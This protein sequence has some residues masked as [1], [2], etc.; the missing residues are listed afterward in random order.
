[1][2]HAPRRFRSLL[3]LGFALP[4]L[5]TFLASPCAARQ[6]HVYPDGSGD[7]PTIAAAIDSSAAGDEILLHPG[8][9][10]EHDLP[11]RGDTALRGVGGAR[12]EIVVDGHVGGDPGASVFRLPEPHY[13]IESWSLEGV[14]LTGANVAVVAGARAELLVTNCV[15]DTCDTGIY[16]GRAD[17]DDCEF[18]DIAHTGS[19]V[20]AN[21]ARGSI[22][23]A[24]FEGI[25]APGSPASAVATGF[26][27]VLENCDFLGNQARTGGAVFTGGET[28]IT[29]CRFVG[30]SA[31]ESGGAL[32]VIGGVTTVTGCTFTG[33][34]ADSGS[35]AFVRAG[36]VLNLDRCLV[37]YEQGDYEI[38]GSPG[39][40]VNTT[41]TD[42]YANGPGIPGPFVRER[43]TGGTTFAADPL[44]CSPG[45]WTIADLS[46]CA[47][48]NSPCGALIGLE[49][50]A[51]ATSG[52]WIETDPPGLRVVGDGVERSAAAF[53]EWGAG[54]THQ[55]AA[56]DS[57]LTSYGIG[58]VFR[59]WDDGGAATHDITVTGSG[60]VATAF[61]DERWELSMEWEGGGAVF[62]GST[63]RVPEEVVTITAV[64][65]SAWVFSHWWGVGDGSYSGSDPVAQVTMNEPILQHAVFAE[66][67]PVTIYSEPPGRTV[68]V[69]GEPVI[70]PAT[71]FWQKHL[72]M[73]VDADAPQEVAPGQRYR[74]VSWSDGGAEEHYVPVSTSPVELTVTY[75]FEYQLSFEQ[76]PHATFLPGDSWHAPGTVLTIEA[77]PDWE[78]AFAGWT[79]TGAASYTGPDNPTVITLDSPVHEDALITEAFAGHGYDFSI[80][81]SSTDPHANVA[82]PTNTSR[83]LYLWGTCLQ[84]GLAAFEAA[85]TG[86][87]PLAGFFPEPGI[88]NAGSSDHLFLAV[89]GCPTGDET[90]TLLG[91]WVITSD[92]GGTL[93]LSSPDGGEIAVA[94][95][96][97]L[98]PVVWPDPGVTGFSSDGSPPCEVG[99]NGCL[100]DPVLVELSGLTAQATDGV[101]TVSWETGLELYHDGFHVY[102]ASLGEADAVRRT[103]TMVRGRSPYAWVDRAVEPDHTYRYWVGAI[104]RAG[105]EQRFGPVEVTTPRPL[106]SVTTFAGPRPTPFR[107]RTKLA[108]ALAAEAPVELTIFDVAGRVVRRYADRYSAGE[109]VVEW[110]ARDSG[111][112]RVQGG[113][114][115]A[116]FRAGDVRETRKLVLLPGR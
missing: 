41:C 6:W 77:I 54:E 69:R 71:F 80:S 106:P 56:P 105:R 3:L 64:P 88:L 8:T 86:T 17:V 110:D 76:E 107:G 72:D 18:I 75:A 34:T 73:L 81:A 87:L 85:V 31:T 10:F 61:Y 43:L 101:V 36:A 109:H 112:R 116:T 78:W 84:R 35:C 67:V 51:C 58:Y 1:M 9:Y 23:N 62:P 98:E 59:E 13:V 104:D 11:L 7:A 70:T 46:P 29:G 25:G 63:L 93:C 57:Q 94:D 28:T 102:R 50:V 4:L 89:G 95:C 26:S 20:G 14:R 45:E 5:F 97:P 47:P 24:R 27:M 21:I 74:F 12:D 2:S 68:L 79:G 113:V 100:E 19:G 82:P 66:A 91:R 40:I 92:A 32:C 65:D 16:S 42:F 96:A 108:F 15:I 52:V 115:F 55:I 114:Y 49:P 60:V 30:N 33:D 111:G 90:D 48:A 37:A 39:A 22:R 38:D 83:V 99:T 103:E 53:F 44:F